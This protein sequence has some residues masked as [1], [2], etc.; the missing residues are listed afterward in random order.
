MEEVI[1]TFIFNG[2]YNNIQ[3]KRCDYM[4][5]I[6]NK[7]SIKAEKNIE[8]LVFLYNGIKINEELR[9]KEINKNEKEIIILLNENSK[10]K[11]NN[12][13]NFPKKNYLSKLWRE[14]FN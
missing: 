4:K 14:L 7:F 2:T 12:G 9:L 11:N 13:I 3:A 1:V 8:N 5:D 6:F 10:T